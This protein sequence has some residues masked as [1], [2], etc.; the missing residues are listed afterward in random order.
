MHTYNVSIYIEPQTE[1]NPH[2]FGVSHCEDHTL[3][4][5]LFVLKN[6]PESV[7]SLAKLMDDFSP[8]YLHHFLMFVSYSKI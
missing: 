4:A 6:R 8:L 7:N 1:A 3:A 5:R 2:S